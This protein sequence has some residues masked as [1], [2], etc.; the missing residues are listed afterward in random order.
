MNLAAAARPYYTMTEEQLQQMLQSGREADFREIYKR[1]SNALYGIL[2]RIVGDEE[3]AQDVLQEAFVKIWRYA[4]K[5]D[6]ARG[7]VF[8]WMLNIARNQAIDFL[9]S[10]QNINRQQS[11]PLEENVGMAESGTA[12]A[13]QE[14]SEVAELV[15]GLEPSLR[16]LIEMVYLDG[17]TQAEAAEITGTPLGTVKTRIRAALQ[18]LRTRL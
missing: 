6:R 4:A 14:R 16:V 17:Y 15:S 13:A 8:T 7:T 12:Q 5:Y 18:K 9:R 2:L 1:Y 11:I 10:R 3:L